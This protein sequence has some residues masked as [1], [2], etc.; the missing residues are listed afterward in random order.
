MEKLNE[1]GLKGIAIKIL[2]IQSHKVNRLKEIGLKYPHIEFRMLQFD[3]L[4]LHRITIIDR[5]KTII[6]KIKDDPKSNFTDAIGITSFIEGE[7]TAWSFTAIFDTLWKQTSLF[8]KI[9]KINQQLQSHAR[10]QKEYLDMV[11]H[12]LRTPIQPIIGLTEYV[13]GKLKDKKQIELLDSV[14]A[15]GQKLNTLTENI[16]DVSRME[17]NFFSIKKERFDLSKSISNII[18]MFDNI[19]KKHMKKIKFEFNNTSKDCFV[20]GDRTRI[21]QVISNLVH[22]S[23]KSISR[24]DDKKEGLISIKIEK[25]KRKST[26]L[27]GTGEMIEVVIEDNGE[28]INPRVIPNLFTKFTKSIDGNGLGLYISKK[29]IEAHNGTMSARNSKRSG[30]K[31]SFS[32]PISN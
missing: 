7:P 20:V 30:A 1:L 12:E 18:K 10:M 13:K 28:G 24:K 22:N 8:E 16:L 3:F 32:L 2:I 23:I 21:E 17:D 4:I 27:R 31:F 25:R 26:K 11:A 9:K 6:I 29:I 19:L 14:I 15:S 5:I